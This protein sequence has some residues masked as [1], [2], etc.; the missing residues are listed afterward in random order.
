MLLLHANNRAGQR[1]IIS[2]PREKCKVDDSLVGLADAGAVTWSF[3]SSSSFYF[4]S[5]CMAGLGM[6]CHENSV[7]WPMLNCLTTRWLQMTRQELLD[8]PLVEVVA[9]RSRILT[10]L[11][12]HH[13][14]KSITW[15]HVYFCGLLNMPAESTLWSYYSINSLLPVLLL[16]SLCLW[17]WSYDNIQA[18]R[19]WDWEEDASACDS[20]NYANCFRALRL[21]ITI[22]RG[23]WHYILSGS[24]SVWEIHNISLIAIPF[25]IATVAPPGYMRGRVWNVV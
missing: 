3:A 10:Y 21:Q 4:S 11:Q 5:P 23:F 15:W 17:I 22:W 19:P 18:R 16:L 20:A 2:S 8:R 6:N 25:A 1:R 13:H 9:S 7:I 14:S 12:L 24:L